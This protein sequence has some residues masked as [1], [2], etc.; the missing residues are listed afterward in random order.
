MAN[1]TARDIL[2]MKRMENS[3]NQ[4]PITTLPAIIEAGAVPVLTSGG[5]RALP[6]DD[7]GRQSIQPV[8]MPSYISPG[9]GIGGGA[10]PG[11][12]PAGILP[13]V[14]PAQDNNIA[15]LL[16]MLLPLLKAIA[17]QLLAAGGG[18]ILGGL[19]GG[20]GGGGGGQ[21][22]PGSNVP[23]GGPGLAEPPAYMVAKEWHANNAQFYMLTDGRI[24]VYS[25]SKRRW[26]VYRP[27]KNL[28]ISRNPKVNSLLQ[29]SGKIDR[30][31]RSL[32]KKSS[33]LKY[34]RTTT[35]RRK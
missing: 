16:P 26:K 19:L 23:L 6:I 20:G 25:K 7:G 11:G 1:W 34:G 29:V 10:L 15:A 12:L 21:V 4:I 13:A 9:V 18:A 27:A 17:P 35:K 8:P 5:I 24:A 28:V 33:V 30:L 2:D 22:I 32:A 14:Q 3:G 31:M